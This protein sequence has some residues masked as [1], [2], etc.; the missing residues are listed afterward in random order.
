M[1]THADEHNLCSREFLIPFIGVCKLCTDNIF[2]LTATLGQRA[3]MLSKNLKENLSLEKQESRRPRAKLNPG[4]TAPHWMDVNSTK[5]FFSSTGSAYLKCQQHLSLN[6]PLQQLKDRKINGRG[7]FSMLQMHTC[8][9]L[10]PLCFRSFDHPLSL[11]T[12]SCSTH[13][14]P[15]I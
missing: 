8:R 1:H 12:V 15:L 10:P 6:L 13:F 11:H 14:I 7:R 9:D 5:S 4:A 2:H 3:V